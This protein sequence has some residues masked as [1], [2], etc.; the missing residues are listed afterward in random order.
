MSKK[1]SF[2][3]TEKYSVKRKVQMIFEKDSIQSHSKTCMKLKVLEIV[4]RPMPLVCHSH[5]HEKGND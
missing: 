5:F 1:M 3:T 4:K 2:S